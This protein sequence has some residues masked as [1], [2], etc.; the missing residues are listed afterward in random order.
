MANSSTHL[1]KGE[2]VNKIESKIQ[3]IIGLCGIT[4]STPTEEALEKVYAYVRD[5][6]YAAEEGFATKWILTSD[7]LPD[8]M[9]SVAFVCDCEGDKDL[10]GR[11]LGGRYMPGKF[12]GFSVP[13]L[14]VNASHWFAMPPV[15]VDRMEAFDKVVV[16]G[17]RIQNG[18]GSHYCRVS[19]PVGVG[20][21]GPCQCIP[22][23]ITM[24][25]KLEVIA[26]LAEMREMARFVDPI[27]EGQRDVERGYRN[28]N[29][30]GL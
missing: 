3:W 19:R 24:E 26:K 25:K 22:R 6:K 16:C 23:G 15:M 11:I 1:R 27:D 18:C 2:T 4:D 30:S 10:H 17:V 29:P 12:G 14:M 20:S 21:N 9:Q 8:P 28:V 13:G 7:R 5:L